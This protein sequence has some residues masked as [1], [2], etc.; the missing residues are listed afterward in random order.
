MPGIQLPK[1]LQESIIEHFR[2]E[3]ELLLTGRLVCSWWL[4]HVRQFL[5]LATT[6]AVKEAQPRKQE[7][8]D[9]TQELLA[10]LSS[11]LSTIGP[12]IK[13]LTIT[14][15]DKLGCLC[16]NS[17]ARSDRS[18]Y[19]AL[20]AAIEASLP[21]MTHVQHLQFCEF[22]FS[23]LS[24]K[25]Q[26]QLAASNVTSL[27]C[28][29]MTYVTLRDMFA[30]FPNLRHL[31][32]FHVVRDYRAEITE[33]PAEEFQP[34]SSLT[35]LSMTVGSGFLELLCSG[36]YIQP[37]SISSLSICCVRE[38]HFP[39]IARLIEATGESLQLLD[40]NQLD[41][42]QVPFNLNHNPSLRTLRLKTYQGSDLS[43]IEN[44]MKTALPEV[45]IE[46]EWHIYHGSDRGDASTSKLAAFYAQYSDMNIAIQLV[47]TDRQNLIEDP[48]AFKD[49]I[50]ATLTEPL[51]RG[52]ISSIELRQGNRF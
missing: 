22:E 32:L 42:D 17:I 47:I 40:F 8:A 4:N 33:E 24:N 25:V 26:S 45:R 20:N 52:F 28:S 15:P 16:C 30:P 14:G 12:F 7:D 6:I 3:Q 43:W 5:S 18:A 2:G 10:L 11:P 9:S 46:L 41:P 35:S 13:K 19:P 48:S 27:D 29:G 50:K 23:Q 51:E 38:S 39:H 37:Q 36:Q 1:E 34:L 49:V 31:K 44:L 21:H